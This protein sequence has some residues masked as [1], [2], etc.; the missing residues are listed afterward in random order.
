MG[1]TYTQGISDLS[2]EQI[3][4]MYVQK[5]EKEIRPL[6]DRFNRIK[7]VVGDTEWVIPTD[8]EY[9]A[10]IREHDEALNELLK[11]NFAYPELRKS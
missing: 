7:D 4:D 11:F 6:E 9:A 5:R 8:P 2:L 10:Q 1:T 3:R